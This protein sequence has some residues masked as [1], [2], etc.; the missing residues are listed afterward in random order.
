M[1][2]TLQVSSLVKIKISFL[3]LFI[4]LCLMGCNVDTPPDMLDFLT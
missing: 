2:A 3:F 4:L 1:V